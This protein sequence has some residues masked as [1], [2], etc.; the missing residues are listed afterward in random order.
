METNIIG[1]GPAVF[2]STVYREQNAKNK[3]FKNLLVFL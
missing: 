3:M 1:T 2:V